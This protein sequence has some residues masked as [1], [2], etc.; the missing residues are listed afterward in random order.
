MEMYNP[1]YAILNSAIERLLRPLVRIL[2]AHDVAFDSFMEITKRAYVNVAMHEFAVPGKRGSIS[3]V[4]TL[5]GLTRKEV[6]RVLQAGSALEIDTGERFDRAARVI[7][8][9]VRDQ[10]FADADGQPRP[11]APEDNSTGFGELVR[12]YS[13]DM[14]MRAMYDELLRVGAVTL[15]P[16]GQLRLLDR[17]YVPRASAADKLGILGTDVADLIRT[18][19]HN[20]ERGMSEPRFQRKV[21]Y[22][23]LPSEAA[24]RFRAMSAVNAQQLLERLDEWLAAHDRDITPGIAGSGRVRAGIGI[25]YFQEDL[26]QDSTEA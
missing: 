16:N 17:A 21:V 12:R 11:L 5:T 24:A 13:G 4:S 23:N 7:A 22:D 18:V 19:D 10:D 6:Q 26:A 8:G 14:P 2:L 1:L 3:Q 25:Y 9:W 15:L 20:F